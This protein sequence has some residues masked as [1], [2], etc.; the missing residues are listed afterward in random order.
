MSSRDDSQPDL[1]SY[2]FRS[3]SGTPI[4]EVSL[5]TSSSTSN[6][7]TQPG[8]EFKTFSK[9]SSSSDEISPDKLHLKS[10]DRSIVCVNGETLYAFPIDATELLGLVLSAYEDLNAKF[11]DEK[12]TEFYQFNYTNWSFNVAVATG[13]LRYKAITA[14]VRR[15]L[16]L[17]PVHNTRRII[18]SRVGCVYHGGEPIA[19][20]AILPLSGDHHPIFA[21]SD[22]IDASHIPQTPVEVQTISPTG[23]TNSTQIMSPWAF[24]IYKSRSAS[25]LP[26]RQVSGDVLMRA[27]NTGFYLTVKILRDD[28]GFL[29][30]AGLYLML[31]PI[32]IALGRWA[33]GVIAGFVF[34]PWVVDKLADIYRL[35]SGSYR[36]GQMTGQFLIQAT[37]RDREGRLVALKADTYKTIANAILGPLTQINDTQKPIYSMG[38]EVLGPDPVNG[39]EKTVILGKWEL[40]VQKSE[41]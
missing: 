39:T 1:A 22:A 27:F 25:T 7:S 29:H 20:V 28:D 21:D 10:H 8:Q 33:L 30:Q 19:D 13:T 35:E 5:D 14:V 38:G 40:R 15:F 18:W 17:L 23:T 24:D 9:S 3:D 34:E 32:L 36:L 2:L 41:L 11:I 16:R 31:I 37:A 6:E 26:R 4:D 12:Q